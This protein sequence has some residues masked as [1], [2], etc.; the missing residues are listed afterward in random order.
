M[1]LQKRV[2]LEIGTGELLSLL[3]SINAMK[4]FCMTHAA[5]DGQ[6][7]SDDVIVE[8]FLSGAMSVL[9]ESLGIDGLKQLSRQLG[10]IE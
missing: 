10:L 3:N 7:I 6:T 4:S 5:R 1:G 2:S 8:N 9:E